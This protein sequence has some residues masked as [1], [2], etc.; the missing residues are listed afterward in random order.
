VGEG[1]G[2]QIWPN[3]WTPPPSGSV[4]PGFSPV[5]G[6]DPVV[7]GTA[8]Q[9]PATGQSIHWGGTMWVK[10]SGGPFTYSHDP[11]TGETAYQ[12]PK[13]G[14]WEVH[15]PPKWFV[16]D[17]EVPPDQ[18]GVHYVNLNGQ[19]IHYSVVQ[20]AWI[21]DATH[22]PLPPRTEEK[23]GTGDEAGRVEVPEPDPNA[24]PPEDSAQDALAKDSI[25]SSKLAALQK[26]DFS[27]PH[28]V[29]SADYRKD[30]INLYDSLVLRQTL[31]AQGASASELK[32]V[33]G[34]IADLA[35]YL[36]LWN[37]KGGA[38]AVNNAA[39]MDDLQAQVGQV[40]K[41]LETGLSTAAGQTGSQVGKFIDSR[42]IGGGGSQTVVPKH[43]TAASYLG[44]EP[45]KPNFGG[46]KT[47]PPEPGK[48]VDPQAKTA[49]LPGKAVDPQVKTAPLAQ[50]DVPGAG[51]ATLPLPDQSKT[52]TLPGGSGKSSGS[53]KPVDQAPTSKARQ[54]A[55]N[56]AAQKSGYADYDEMEMKVNAQAARKDALKYQD[57]DTLY[58]KQSKTQNPMTVADKY[59]KEHSLSYTKYDPGLNAIKMKGARQTLE[60]V[61]AGKSPQ[62]KSTKQNLETAYKDYEA[63]QQAVKDG[64]AKYPDYDQRMT[65]TEREFLQAEAKAAQGKDLKYWQD[66]YTANAAEGKGGDAPPPTD[67]SKVPPIPEANAGRLNPDYVPAGTAGEGTA[68][69]PGGAGSSSMALPQSTRGLSNVGRNALVGVIIAG[70]L[71][72]VIFGMTALGGPGA[73]APPTPGVSASAPASTAPIAT[74]VAPTAPTP[75]S[76]GLDLSKIQWA[77]YTE[78][79]RNS[80]GSGACRYL[81]T[82]RV[83]LR[84]PTQEL[85]DA[86]LGRTAVVTLSGPGLPSRIEVPL[87]VNGGNIGEFGIVTKATAG[88][89]YQAT[90]VS[91]AGI[92]LD[93]VGDTFTNP[94]K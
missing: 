41:I 76:V 10:D 8:F 44:K 72:A 7:P 9:N 47:A 15:L 51:K 66:R 53:Q 65:A 11:E 60:D 77:I 89:V 59:A 21:D 25:A 24:A 46:G 38:H 34:H 85:L 27:V 70:L 1:H 57:R 68:P 54:D 17:D 40:K 71:A 2:Q 81:V 26:G 56:K 88:A 48:A 16:V 33:E 30:L 52:A 74:T 45:P 75:S 22:L 83:D 42:G 6:G 63:A 23:P 79:Q 12:N 14:A 28:G 69:L 32:I 3:G 19:R 84:A 91:A 31:I 39:Q 61:S 86:V 58:G 62:I 35:K 20:G 37:T 18:L 92:Q 49:P 50:G 82:A 64:K 93:L 80:D 55:A 90:L 4:P 43:K 94:C 78:A 36:K 29:S 67:W 87:T 73:T 13:T 5:P